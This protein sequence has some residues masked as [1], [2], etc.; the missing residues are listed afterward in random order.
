MPIM[1]AVDHITRGVAA[2]YCTR[3]QAGAARGVR[4][5]G[6]RGALPR[7]AHHGAVLVSPTSRTTIPIPARPRCNA[8]ETTA[9]YLLI[10]EN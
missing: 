4:G 5:Q 10:P 6:R 3:V 2:G 9:R 7:A 1:S 8:N